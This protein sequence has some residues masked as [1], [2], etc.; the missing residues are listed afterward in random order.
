MD[1]V[2]TSALP[3][4]ALN[5]LESRHR[6]RVHRGDALKDERQLKGFIGDADGVV[7]LLEN[8]VTERVLAGCPRLR[9]VANCAVGYDNIDLEA[10]RRRG[11]WVTNTP[12]VLTEATA[13]LTWA[14]I[15]GVTRRVVES[16]AF[17]RQGRY[18]GWA[19]DLLLGSGLQG[20]TLGIVGFGR[21][22]SAVARRAL[23]FG[24][25]VAYTDR[26]PAEGSPTVRFL[27]LEELLATSHVV[28]LHCPLTDETRHLLDGRRL[29]LLPRGAFVINTARGPLIDE[30]ALVR[31]LE[32]GHLGGAGLDV[33]EDEPRVQP[34]LLQR[35]DTVLLPHVG[36]ATLET[37]A[38]MADLAVANL[39]AVLDG[40]EPTTPVVR[41]R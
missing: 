8:P 37:R 16:D 21:I 27:D 2:A 25:E 4:T 5:E 14:L 17:L 7:T 32:A 40:E 6:L 10:A 29:G 24:M 35:A 18:R 41:G 31:A 13:D 11:V 30:A 39:M 36:S 28:S 38:A 23:A 15:L 19:P 20:R 12:D 9:V 26:Q 3:G 34:G 1:V 33:F 22:G